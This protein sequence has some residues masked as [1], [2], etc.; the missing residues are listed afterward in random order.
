MKQ[1][2][3]AVSSR[4]FAKWC[5][6]F[7]IDVNSRRRVMNEKFNG[8]ASKVAPLSLCLHFLTAL[9]PLLTR[10]TKQKEKTSGR[11]IFTSREFESAIF[12]REEWKRRA[13][14]C[15]T[16]PADATSF[17][18]NRLTE[19]VKILYSHLNSASILDVYMYIAGRVYF[20][21]L[22]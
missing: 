10:V 4:F 6:E 13:A 21:R 3:R 12:L 19:P 18:D 14:R 20:V 16:S 5:L 11:E 9:F 17:G 7:S 15:R 8:N 1:L 22:S 2:Y